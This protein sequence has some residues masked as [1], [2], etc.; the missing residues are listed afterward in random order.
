MLKPFSDTTIPADVLYL[1]FRASLMASFD[2]MKLHFGPQ[3]VSITGR[4]PLES[5]SMLRGTAIQVQMQTLVETWNQLQPDSSGGISDSDLCVSYCAVN[6]LARQTELNR[7]LHISR[8]RSGPRAF[9]EL[10]SLWVS[11]RLRILQLTWPFRQEAERL[12]NSGQLLNDQLDKV[13]SPKHLSRL[14]YHFFEL[15]GQWHVS[16]ELIKKTQ[17]LLTEPEKNEL[18]RFFQEHQKL[19][20][21]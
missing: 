18:R 14:D 1:S 9:P 7:E 17:G 21:L 13:T 2:L 10:T 4:G 20:N 16:P 19:M 6:E 11:S 12:L 5:I 8:L 3:K 15:L